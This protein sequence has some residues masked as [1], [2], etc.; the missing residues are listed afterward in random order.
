M[1]V[2]ILLVGCAKDVRTRYPSD[3]SEPVGSVTLVFTRPSP[4]VYVAINGHLVVNGAHTSHIRVEGV[5]TGYADIAIAVGPGEKAMRVWVDE[6]SNMV[7]PIGAPG[8][9]ALDSLKSMAMSLAAI[10]LY[11]WI[12]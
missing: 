2:L 8:G 12:R 3:P 1:V 5:A 6:G 4:D 9:S 7:I 10:A 11:A